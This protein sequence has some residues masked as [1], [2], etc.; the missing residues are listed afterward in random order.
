M[1]KPKF[2]LA[3]EISLNGKDVKASVEFEGVE[4]NKGVVLHLPKGTN[5]SNWYHRVTIKTDLPE[6]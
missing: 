1:M 3:G 4:G 5:T 2:S 6:Q